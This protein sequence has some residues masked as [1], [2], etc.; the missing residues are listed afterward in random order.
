LVITMGGM[1]VQANCKISDIESK[2]STHD[3][4]ETTLNK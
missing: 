3:W 2:S 1:Y 4:L